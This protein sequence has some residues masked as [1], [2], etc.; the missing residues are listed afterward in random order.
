MLDRQIQIYSVDTG[1]FYSKH[2]EK[3]HILNHKLKTERKEVKEK[4]AKYEKQYAESNSVFDWANREYYKLVLD[5]KNDA[6]NKSKADLK[7]LLARKTAANIESGG[8]A[9]TRCLHDTAA[10]KAQVIS[11]FDSA[12]TRTLGAKTDTLTDAF[13]VVQVYYFEIIKDL[14]YNGFEWNGE[15]YIYFT[16]SAG[17]IRTKKCVFIKESLYKEHE[18]TI[19]CGLTLDDINDAGGSNPNKFLAYLALQN[20]ATDEWTEFDIDKAI[21]IDDFETNVMGTYDLVDD[22]A[23]SIERTEGLVPIPHTDGC[24]MMLPKM[25]CNRIVRLPWIKGLLASF[26]YVSFIR[27]HGASPVIKDI[28]GK[29]H[30]VIA[31]GIEVIFTKSQF[32]MY[33]FYPSWENYK[34]NFKKYHCSAGVASV[35]E[36]RIKNATINYQ[37]LQTLT[38]ITDD[39]IDKL[40]EPSIKAITDIASSEESIKEAINAT[41]YNLHPTAFQKAVLLYPNLLN[42][43][44]VKDLLAKI[45]ASLIKKFK[46]GKLKVRGKY[47]FLLPDLYAACEFWFLGLANPKGLLDD[48]EVYCDLFRKADKL[49]CLRSPHLY[50]EHAVRK[51]VAYAGNEK[52]ERCSKWFQTNAVYTSTHDLISKI[53]QFDNRKC[54]TCME[55]SG[56]KTR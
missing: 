29:E 3:L 54:Q 22:E 19:M 13:V 25:G 39:E 26:D 24:G 17:Q 14:I 41:V 30:D 11:V 16:S 28:Y 37:M 27:E 49:D 15:R 23:Y 47:T 48:G 18:K 44:Y 1:N 7:A 50:R 34:E 4:I 53:L 6:I 38:D 2:E 51:N 45:K 36:I 42:D 12:L 9:Y 40:I 46:A 20:S 33:K 52:R 8:K 5:K 10:S 43:A 55:T 56:Y 21:V 31:E 35:E 32:K